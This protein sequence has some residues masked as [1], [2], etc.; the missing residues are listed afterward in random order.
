MA[1][2]F[3]ARSHSS[4][5][6]EKRPG[7]ADHLVAGSRCGELPCSR[8]GSMIATRRGR[9]HVRFWHK[10]DIGHPHFQCLFKPLR[11]LVLSLGTILKETFCPSLRVLASFDVY[12]S[13]VAFIV[14]YT[15]GWSGHI[16][17]WPSVLSEDIRIFF[18]F[19]ENDR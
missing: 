15:A 18:P 13:T 16:S 10:A 8:A 4:S 17:R 6:R 1:L 5:G 7:T 12:Q 9:R 14:H 3:T 19:W 11:C 2:I